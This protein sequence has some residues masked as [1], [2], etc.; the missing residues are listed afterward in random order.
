MS[1]D[2][3]SSKK[4]YFGKYR[5]V[6]FNN[7][8]VEQKGRIQ[9][10]VVDVLGMTPTTWALPCLPLTGIV[11]VQ[12]GTFFLPPLDANVWIEFEHGDVNYPIWSGC[13]WGTQSQIPLV[14][15]AGTPETAPIVMQTVGQNILWIG[16]DP[17]TGI[18]ISCGPAATP[19]SPQIKI[20]QTGIL[21]TDGKGG[22]ILVSLGAVSI[23]N[24]ALLI[25]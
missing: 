4:K 1:A 24:G 2:R 10:L 21:I 17:V 22:T 3:P 23:N 7:A 25:K 9:A 5:G 19:S 16:G 8:D 20:S 11:G 15:L 14:A 6:V 13:F 12:S 18:T